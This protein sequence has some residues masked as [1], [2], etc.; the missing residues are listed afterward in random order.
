[1]SDA[2]TIR[3]EIDGS[4]ARSGAREVNR[5]L[6]DIKTGANRMS[7][8]FRSKMSSLKKELFSLKGGLVSLAG[9]LGARD[10]IRT[11]VQFESFENAL[12][13]ATGSTHNA[14][15][16][17]KFLKNE[18]SRLGVELESLVGS[19]T[20]FASASKGTSLEG[21]QTRKI[22][23]SVAQ[24]SRVLGLSADQSEGALLA[25]SQM[26]SKGKVQAEELRGQLG[27]RL[28]GAFQLAARSMGV[29]TAELDKMLSNGEVIAAD[30]LPKLADELNRT[31]GP[32]VETAAQSSAASFAR[33]SNAITELKV[34]IGNSGIV[35]GLAYI[36]EGAVNVFKKSGMVIQSFFAAIQKGFIDIKS[37]F[38]MYIESLSTMFTS[39][40]MYIKSQFLDLFETIAR[41]LS[42][43]PGLE[44]QGLGLMFEVGKLEANT[45]DFDQALKAR[46]N[47]IRTQAL[48]EK[49]AIDDMMIDSFKFIFDDS[50]NKPNFNDPSDDDLA[51]RGS[52][53]TSSGDPSV[54]ADELAKAQDRA[55]MSLNRL[56]QDL[57]LQNATFNASE[58]EMMKYRITT[59]DLSKELALLGEEGIVAKQKILELS[60]S[61]EQKRT[62]EEK[63]EAAAQKRKEKAEAAER[64][65]K[66]KA[67]ASAQKLREEQERINKVMAE[68]ASITE[69]MRTP[70]ESYEATL[71]NLNGLLEQGAISQETYNRALLSAQDD[72]KSASKSSADE[73]TKFW[74][75]AGSAMQSTMSDGFF[76]VMQGDLK[77]LG[78]NFKKTIDRM[79]A[80]LLASQLMDSIGGMFGAGG[81]P[82]SSGGSGDLISSI[83]GSMFG[84]RAT[85]GPV[86]AGQPYIVGEK[87]PEVFVP[88]T[89]GNIVP[90]HRAGS[91]SGGENITVHVNVTGVRDEGGLRQSAAQVGADT[92]RAISRTRRNT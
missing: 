39:P 88:K 32:E 18:S 52:G 92:A 9:A 74:I 71:Q 45:K 12:K 87:T 13:A 35:D 79:V 78:D 26:I 41:G 42:H 68:G 36:A 58:A 54:A 81:S 77:N 80:D 37:Y 10:M 31:F 53:G 29:T 67:A 20:K 14:Q 28:P 1:M 90:T 64:K 33:F 8:T 38:D 70:L 11:T 47:I 50:N 23:T 19:Y 65:R 34:Q 60:Q 40:L 6:R 75:E 4:G 30:M 84:F 49:K 15:A 73:I 82:G 48:A 76:G 46:L 89:N 24:A 43:V 85:G 25:L 55:R 3:V 51:G 61:L 27:E 69:S 59:G 63:A 16:S 7:G 44:S 5:A 83:A 21:E 86:F 57:E 17:M 66:E 91:S 22:F 56:M 62:A 2:R 72:F